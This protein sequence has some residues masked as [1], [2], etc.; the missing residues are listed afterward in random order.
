[1]KILT[2]NYANYLGSLTAFVVF[3][4]LLMTVSVSNSANTSHRKKKRGLSHKYLQIR[5]ESI[6]TRAVNS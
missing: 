1:M 4:L 2:Q 5:S 3:F 6:T